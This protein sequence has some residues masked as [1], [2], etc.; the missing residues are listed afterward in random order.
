MTL[1]SVTRSAAERDAAMRDARD[2][3]EIID[4]ACELVAL[5][6]RDLRGPDRAATDRAVP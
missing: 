5:P 1:R 4:Q 2:V 3:E 6:P